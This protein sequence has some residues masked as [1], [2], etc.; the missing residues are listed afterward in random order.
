MPITS[1]HL[2]PMAAIVALCA[3]PV[4]AFAGGGGPVVRASGTLS[5]LQ[6]AAAGPFDGATAAVQIVSSGTSSHTVLRVRGIDGAEGQTFG[7]H[8]HLGPCVAGN[9]AAALGP[10]QHRRARRGHAS[11]DQ[12]GHRGLA[13]LHGRRRRGHRDGIRPVRAA[14]R[15]RGRSSSTRWR[16]TTTPA[17][18]G[19]GWPAS[20]WSG[21]ADPAFRR[22]RLRRRRRV[23]RHRAGLHAAAH[24]LARIL[25]VGD[26]V[27]P[28]RGGRGGRLHRSGPRGT[29]GG[30]IGLVAPCRAPRPDPLRRSGDASPARRGRHGGGPARRTRGADA[31]R[32]GGR[33]VTARRGPLRRVPGRDAGPSSWVS[34]SWCCRRYRSAGG[35]ARSWAAGD[36]R[37]EGAAASAV[38]PAP[39]TAPVAHA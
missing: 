23:G 27:H 17:P 18:Q 15:A 24:H 25:V 33:R 35:S 20:R 12:R 22:P 8:L 37:R 10:L 36:P 32:G 14:P 3:L 5:D 38:R 34:S 9:G 13:R 28:R 30:T 1:R 6:I 16:P 7:A 39:L 4:P 29:P 19:R 26:P 21:D 2:V 31:G 11:G